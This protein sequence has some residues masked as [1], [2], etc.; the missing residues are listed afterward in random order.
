MP[1]SPDVS[2]WM[3]DILSCVSVQIPA[4]FTES[5]PM[6]KSIRA[7]L[8][9]SPQLKSFCRYTINGTGLPALWSTLVLHIVVPF[10]VVAVVGVSVTVPLS[11]FLYA[12]QLELNTVLSPSIM[13]L[14]PNILCSIWLLALMNHSRSVDSTLGRCRS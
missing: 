2:E 12:A 3:I 5:S 8:G 4:K 11:K 6:S 1:V 10:G 14:H 7:V 9:V 13:L